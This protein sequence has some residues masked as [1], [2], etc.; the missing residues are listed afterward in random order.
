MTNTKKYHYYIWHVPGQ[1]LSETLCTTESS[2]EVEE[3]IGESTFFREVS[4]AEYNAEREY[5]YPP[6]PFE[7]DL[8]IPQ[9]PWL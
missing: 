8:H 3:R 9:N 4:E 6:D 2:E 1:L 5:N 7:K